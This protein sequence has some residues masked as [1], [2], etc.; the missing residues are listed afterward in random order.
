MRQCPLSLGLRSRRD[1][2]RLKV[3][4]TPD[5]VGFPAPGEDELAARLHSRRRQFCYMQAKARLARRDV[6]LG[7]PI[8][9]RVADDRLVG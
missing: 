1:D 2:T 9:A 7:L 8:V 6:G 3:L 4:P 5:L